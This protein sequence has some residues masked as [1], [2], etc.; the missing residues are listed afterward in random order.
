M[1]ALK[2][3]LSFLYEQ[4]YLYL[5][6]II[7][8]P[9][10]ALFMLAGI[11]ACFLPYAFATDYYVDS[12]VVINIPGTSYNWL[13]IG[14]YGLVFT[15]KL[16]GTEWYNPYYTGILLILFLWLTG[17]TFSYVASKLFVHLHPAI[18]VLSGLILI[19]YPTF[20]E[21]Y[22]FHFQSAE[23]AFGLWLSMLAAGLFTLF[24]REGRISCFV[25]SLPVYVLTFSI[26]QSFVPLTLCTYLGIFL[27]QIM[28]KDA[29]A[30]ILKRGIAGSIL[31]F[32]AAFI[33]SQ[34]IDKLFFPTSG[35]LND[36]VIWTSGVS[37]WEALF[38][39]LE[40]CA[41]MFVGKGVFYTAVLPVAIISA[42][43]AFR[44]LKN[45]PTY[46]LVLG[47][48]SAMGI[49]AT[50]FILTLLMAGE[51][52][53]R[54]QFT[55]SLAAVFL[56]LFGMDTM[57]AYKYRP[58]LKYAWV[59]LLTVV[60]VSQLLTVRF[61]WKAHQYVSDY[62]RTT[63]TEI[64]EMMY[65]SHIICDQIAPIFWGYLQPESPYDEM[66]IGSPSYL[67]TSV[68]NLEHGAEPYCYYST[69]R[70]LGYMETMGHTFTIPTHYQQS[71][72]CYI[73]RREELPAFPA[74]GC[75]FN[76]Y[77]VFTLNLGNSPAYYY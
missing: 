32:F 25:I 51:T 71:V 37:F 46:Q 61:I 47:I 52:A 48:L 43:F 4:F 28:R 55:Y 2:K 72:S 10:S 63:A 3:E 74:K 33:L 15:R 60:M 77:Q 26:Y 30:A 44:C 53:I 21:Q 68:F 20:T 49:A 35:Y 58:F 23:I 45:L 22:Y 11:L 64:L 8:H 27:S 34:S 12:E 41:R 36:Q 75:I 5:L 54:S 69:V 38:S 1:K 16:L 18:T 6:Y 19:T 13:E 76:D 9:L 14:R 39:V 40:A 7:R 42:I 24:I 17:M 56:L 62:D 59:A 66:L 57:I 70:V 67:F 29:S 73:M 50:P 65:D 31:H